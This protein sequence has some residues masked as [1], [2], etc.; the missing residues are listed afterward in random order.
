MA[1]RD[2]LNRAERK[3]I[4]EEINLEDNNSRKRESQ[5][6]F[7]VY[8]DRQDEYILEQLENEFDLKTVQEMRT[9]LSINLSKRIIDEQSSIYSKPP[10]REYTNA[11]EKE[12]EQIENLYELGRVNSSMKIANRYY[13]L[14][15]Q[16]SL[17]VLPKNGK[18][19][20]KPMGTMHYDVIPRDDDP[21][22]AFAYILNV[23]DL[24]N[25]RTTRNGGLTRDRNDYYSSDNRNQTIADDDDRKSVQMRY[26]VWTEEL[27][28]TMDGKG[29]VIGEVVANPIGRLP[30]VDVSM[31][32]DNQFFVRRGSS[33]TNFSIEFGAGL[34]D[35][36]NI[37][38]LQGYAQAVMTSEKQP[39]NIT[40]GPNHILW[41]PLDPNAPETKPSFEFV[42]PTPDI[43][44]G[45][46]L[47]EAQVKFFLSSRGIDP[48][49]VSG[50]GDA[51]SF[52][53]GIDRLLSMLDKFEASQ[54]DYDLFERVEYKT[55]E[56]VK[57]WSNV[58]QG[59]S[60]EARLRDELNLATIS[61]EVFQD[62]KFRGP[63]FVKTDIEKVDEIERKI[64]LGL[65]SQVEAIMIDRNIN[66]ESAIEV[67]KKISE[68][69]V[70][71]PTRP[72]E[73]PEVEEEI[74]KDE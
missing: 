62:V 71:F 47:L 25:Q 11:S 54:D 1:E 48:K 6:R 20:V 13:N 39:Q 35:L 37:N 34:S 21:E 65:I 69:E 45:L 3:N 58:M 66:E 55:F 60:D 7:D 46:E 27:H 29:N 28:F 42:S 26:I 12:L 51:R 19:I 59:V 70:L 57:D 30:F 4:I 68:Q 56:L 38:R 9:V 17:M 14:F 64:E 43:S 44:A 32:K 52:T 15:N 10:D 18:I 8:N 63:E 2:L 53:S 50:K 41:L 36:A 24:D 74:G 72:V 5:R 33:T 73:E 61:D 23:W 67:L 49:T 16:T 22:K 40:V 31:E